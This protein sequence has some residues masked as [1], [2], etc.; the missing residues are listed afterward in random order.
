[1]NENNKFTASWLPDNISKN[2]KHHLVLMKKALKRK[3]G[4][5]FESANISMWLNLLF[6]CMSP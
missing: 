2:C 6:Y 5:F 4:G 3:R 1:M